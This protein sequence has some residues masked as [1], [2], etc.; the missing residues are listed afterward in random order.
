ML[1]TQSEEGYLLLPTHATEIPD[2]FFISSPVSHPA[3]IHFGYATP[4]D[5]D[6]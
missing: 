5:K 6:Y 4:A 2:D 1:K 3:G